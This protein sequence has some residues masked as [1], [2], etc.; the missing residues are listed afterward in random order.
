MLRDSSGKS[1]KTESTL[2]DLIK[3]NKDI[4]NTSDETNERIAASKQEAQE[5]QD[6][7]NDIINTSVLEDISNKFREKEDLVEEITKQ[8]TKT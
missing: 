6:G 5:V 1:L 2:N 4:Q 3:K 7:L 8:K